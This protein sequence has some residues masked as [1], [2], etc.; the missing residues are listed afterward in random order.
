LLPTKIGT[1]RHCRW[2]DFH[3]QILAESASDEFV[4]G[5]TLYRRHSGRDEVASPGND[6]GFFKQVF[7]LLRVN[8]K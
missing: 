8:A 5:S 3:A 1:R 6:G 4:K 7:T 2:R